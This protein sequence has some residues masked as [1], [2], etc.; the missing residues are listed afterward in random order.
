M[1]LDNIYLI[2]ELLMDYCK[3]DPIIQS[4]KNNVKMESLFTYL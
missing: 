2:Q 3:I 4:S 1:F